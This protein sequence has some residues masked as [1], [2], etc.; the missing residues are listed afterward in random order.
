MRLSIRRK[1]TQ[2]AEEIRQMKIVQDAVDDVL[3][4][5]SILDN[6]S[7]REELD[8]AM[9]KLLASLGKYSMSD[10]SYIFTWTGGDRS[11]LQ[12]SHE[13]C[14]DGVEPTIDKMQHVQIEHMPNWASRLR[15]GEAIVSMDW[16]QE[17]EVTP[18]EYTLFDG[19]NISALI[20]IPIFSNKRLNGYIGF[21][22]PEQSK[23]G[24]SL[25]LL[26][27]V[28]GHIGGLQENLLMMEEQERQKAELENALT[29][30]TL[31]SEIV[32]SI[33]K[34]YWLIYRMDLVRGTYEE[35]SAGQ[36]MHRLTGKR[37]TITDVF[38]NVRETIVDEDHQEI[39]KAFLDTSTLADR[40]KDTESVAAE[41]RAA[42]GSWH[43][44]RFIVKKRGKDGRVTNVLYVVREI[45]KQKQ[46]EI[47][48][49]QKLLETA[50]E[51][52]RANIAK[53]D[54]L[55]RMSH[56][57]RTPINGIMGMLEIAEHF[58]EDKEKQKECRDKIKEATGFLMNLVNSVLD[59]NK[60]ESG[61]IELDHEPFDIMEVLHESNNI[62]KMSADT[63]HLTVT[64]D[65]G[66]LKHPHVIGSSIHLKQILQNIAG[67][68]VKYN[69]EGG[70]IRLSC[71][72]TGERDGKIIYRFRCE[73]TGRGMSEEFVQHAFEPFA[74]EE[75]SARTAYMGTG[76]GLA[77]A[78]Q[79]AE[80]MGGKIDVVSKLG[81]GTTFTIE[82][83][84]EVDES[85]E[86]KDIEED[87][88]LDPELAGKKVL[89]V[90]DNDLN[91]EI[92][93]FMLE[94]SGLE[95]T[96]AMNGEMAVEIFRMSEEGYFDF[97][98]MDIMMPVMDGLTATRK[99][100]ELER[101]DA[102]EVPVFAM[103]ANAFTEDKEESKEAGMNEHLSKPL[104]EKTMLKVM[105]KYLRRQE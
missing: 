57:I 94:R 58:A 99:I 15:A 90:E 104:D 74:Q 4:N 86:K 33:S 34:I 61:V 92:A 64:F 16:N 76:L 10:R 52:K 37:G 101:T 65:H 30:A 36:E 73:D 55:R 83:P 13:W 66:E 78:K 5:I 42:N 91:M 14:A 62:T 63:K 105:K 26:K 98:L 93:G 70:T 44:G 60:L 6:I 3:D 53:T 46:M 67:N 87:V 24:L 19:Q 12:M 69:R 84:F 80:M 31:N 68:A 103:T 9:P 43:L 28:G 96:K 39:M 35:I 82:I 25:R 79:L 1:N 75:Q 22:N 81:A 32:G 8:E 97:V 45:D 85:Y 51:A 95:V 40:L 88:I 7:S 100:R 59:M 49:R 23:T 89:L 54:F 11:V 29:E 71:K 102:R 47:E 38:K 17:K 21:D 56:D 2:Q 72:E 48:Y 50:E 20:V 41:Y 77:I 18:E 27:A